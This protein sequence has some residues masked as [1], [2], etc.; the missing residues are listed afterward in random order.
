MSGRAE[1]EEKARRHKSRA[2]RHAKSGNE[3][4]ARAHYGRARYYERE[5]ATG[6]LRVVN[7]ARATRDA[8][9]R[10]INSASTAERRIAGTVGALVAAGLLAKGLNVLGQDGSPTVDG[11]ANTK[12]DAIDIDNSLKADPSRASGVEGVKDSARDGA[13]TG[14]AGSER[15][16]VADTEAPLLPYRATFENVGNSCYMNAVLQ[17]LFRVSDF[18]VNH[19]D[20]RVRDAYT[21]LRGEWTRGGVIQAHRMSEF[22]AAV[23]GTRIETHLKFAG[24][25]QEDAADLLSEVLLRSADDDTDCPLRF[26]CVDTISKRR[27]NARGF[28]KSATMEAKTML[29]LTLGNDTAEDPL[30][31]ERLLDEYT[32]NETLE[33]VRN[34]A[35]RQVATT[36]E[37]R[38]ASFPRALIIGLNRFLGNPQRKI[39]TPVAFHETLDLKRMRPAAT[40]ATAQPCD[41]TYRLCGVVMH[42]GTATGGHYWALVRDMPD[43]VGQGDANQAGQWRRY[44]DRTITD[45]MDVEGVLKEGLGLGPH[46]TSAYIL[47]YARV[48][49]MSHG[50]MDPATATAAPIK[51]GTVDTGK[52]H[53]SNSPKGS[54]AKNVGGRRHGDA[55]SRLLVAHR[56]ARR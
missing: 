11:S 28:D 12:N 8:T 27:V 51:K 4:S 32:K 10:R 19:E 21:T 33:A 37:T 18:R 56:K 1:I 38:I 50:R 54:M 36:K 2:R 13:D 44:D 53:A 5:A 45:N 49:A 41:C 3:A 9:V 42:S 39:E 22:T 30:K 52:P 40:T 46:S 15:G 20:E 23:V 35:G 29:L 48:D 24:T 25:T 26:V 14:H 16:L 43:G 47:F 17:C 6:L 34:D 7:I 31:L 55:H